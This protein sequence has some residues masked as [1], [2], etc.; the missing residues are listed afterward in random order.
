MCFDAWCRRLEAAGVE[1]NEADLRIVGLVASREC[2]LTQLAAAV[3]GELDGAAQLALVREERLAA[4]AMAAAIDLLERTFGVQAEAVRPVEL[5]AT[6]TAGRGGRVVAFAGAASKVKTAA[7]QRIVA[8]VNGA[9]HGLTFPALRRSVAG[10]QGAFRAGLR[11]AVACGAIRRE[12]RG[13]RG[14]PF[15]YLPGGAR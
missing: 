15:V 3:A 13:T 12:G 1:L 10:S 9:A 4:S 2:R 6:G 5:Q 8:A 11:E 14:A 7:G